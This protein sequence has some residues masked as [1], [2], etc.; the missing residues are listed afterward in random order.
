VEIPRPARLTCP[1]VIPAAAAPASAC[2]SGLSV[3]MVEDVGTP[4]DVATVLPDVAAA[5]DVPDV[6][7]VDDAPPP[8]DW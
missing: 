6:P 3:T 2:A 5:P 8:V 4:A 1:T 7:A